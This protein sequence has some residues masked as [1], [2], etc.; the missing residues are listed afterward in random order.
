VNAGH[1]VPVEDSSPETLRNLVAHLELSTAFEHFVYREAEL[2]ALWRLAEIPLTRGRHELAPEEEEVLRVVLDAARGAHDMVGAEQPLAAAD[3]L[4]A[5]IA[6]L[7]QSRR[8]DR[9]VGA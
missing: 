6:A 1:V 2:D 4:R 7:A 3:R 9:A 5:L 8:S